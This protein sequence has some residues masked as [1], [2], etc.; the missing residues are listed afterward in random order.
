[1]KNIL[2][3]INTFEFIFQRFLR[4]HMIRKYS[5]NQEDP[6]NYPGQLPMTATHPLRDTSLNTKSQE[7]YAHV[8]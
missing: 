4:F 1:M 3:L 7:V 8:K 6:F 2:R 5:I